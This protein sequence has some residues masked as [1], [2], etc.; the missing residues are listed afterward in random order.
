MESAQ[1]FCC[2]LR[3]TFRKLTTANPVRRPAKQRGR[4]EIH[5]TLRRTPAASSR[6][7]AGKERAQKKKNKA[8]S[9]LQRY[10]RGQWFHSEAEWQKESQE[11]AHCTGCM[12]QWC[13]N[14]GFTGFN[15]KHNSQEVRLTPYSVN[16]HTYQLQ[17]TSKSSQN[18]VFAQQLR[19]EINAAPP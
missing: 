9:L 3:G 12:Q 17:T 11:T 7:P 2:A 19:S 8:L 16:Q 6:R 15:R 1:L 10:S 5:S 18:D 4:P 13:Q 14:A